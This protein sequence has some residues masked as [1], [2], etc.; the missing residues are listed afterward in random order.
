VAGRAGNL[1]ARL[2]EDRVLVT[3]R[4][5]RKDRLRPGDLVVVDLPASG[6]SGRASSELPAHRACYRADPG[7]G[8]VL[9]AHAPTLIAAGIRGLDIGATLPEVEEATGPIVTVPFAPSGSEA[10]ARAV[11]EAVAAGATVVLL[12]RHGVIATGPDLEAAFDRLE[13]A[14]LSARACL[15]A[16]ER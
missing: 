7:V 10:L 9:H 2:G 12:V 6:G 16:G 11:G 8:A 14:E 15:L 3:P 1:S 4:G 13:L 5:V